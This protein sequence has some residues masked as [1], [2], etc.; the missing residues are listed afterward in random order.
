MSNIINF[1][2][3]LTIIVIEPFT[4]DYISYTEFGEDLI[5]EVNTKDF[6]KDDELIAIA[7]IKCSQC[8]SG[9]A[10][11]VID[12]DLEVSFLLDVG[13]FKTSKYLS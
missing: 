7:Q 3:P 9:F 8:I 10:Y 12:E 5:S 1:R 2:S 6:E 13:L 11:V 4:N